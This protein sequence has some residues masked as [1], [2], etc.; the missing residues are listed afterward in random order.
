MSAGLSALRDYH[1]AHR[2]ITPE[3]A[4]PLDSMYSGAFVD[5]GQ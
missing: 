4:P 5:G 1:V 2:I 3:K